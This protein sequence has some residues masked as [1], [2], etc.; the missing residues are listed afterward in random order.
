MYSK[1]RKFVL[2]S[3][4]DNIIKNL[5]DFERK[6]NVLNTTILMKIRNA[7][8]IESLLA[9]KEEGLDKRENEIVRQ[10]NELATRQVDFL[11]RDNRLRYWDKVFGVSAANALVDMH[12]SD[13]DMSFMHYVD[14]VSAGRHTVGGI[15][16]KKRRIID[17]VDDDRD[18]Q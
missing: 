16:P 4:V 8:T 5:S 11:R 9:T 10:E 15:R 18:G 7:R 2:A 13:E 6:L 3:L 1:C 14:R 17:I 12:A